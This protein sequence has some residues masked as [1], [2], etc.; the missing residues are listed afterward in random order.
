MPAF[1]ALPYPW[2][3]HA[4]FFTESAV[5]YTFNMRYFSRKTDSLIPHSPEARTQMVIW[6]PGNCMAASSQHI[7]ILTFG[8]HSLCA[9][10]VVVALVFATIRDALP[11]NPVAQE[12]I[13]GAF[14]S[15]MVVADVGSFHL[16]YHRITFFQVTK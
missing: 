4:F 13:L 8:H 15:V 6:Q 7:N 12:R 9:S 16:I 10:R 5:R 1:P 2:P 14:L 11:G 3:Y